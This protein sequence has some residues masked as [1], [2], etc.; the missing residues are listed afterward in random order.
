MAAKQKIAWSYNGKESTTNTP[1][2]V[3]DLKVG[4]IIEVQVPGP[5][6]HGFITIKKN[7]DGQWTEIKD[8]V[9][10]C[11]ENAGSKPNAVLREI[12]CGAASQFGVS[13]KG[14]MRLEVLTTFSSDTDFWCWVH[15]R[16]MAGTLKLKN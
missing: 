12:D 16:A 5:F 6:P 4:D 3:D 10:T 13:F 2:V 14:S 7:A 8:P 9:L 11:G 15:K 1:I